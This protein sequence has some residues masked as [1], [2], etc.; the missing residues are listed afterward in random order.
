MT[1]A[2]AE[3]V[4]DIATLLDNHHLQKVVII[5]DAYNDLPTFDD[6]DED[7]AESIYQILIANGELLAQ[8][9]ATGMLMA[10][11]EDVTQ[12][13]WEF[14]WKLAPTDPALRAELE[15]LNIARNSTLKILG[16]LKKHLEG[17]LGRAVLEVAAERELPDASAQILFI[18]YFLDGTKRQSSLQIAKRLGQ[19][20]IELYS[21]SKSKPVIILMS[22]RQELTDEDKA[23]FRE[24]ANFVGGMFHYIPKKD[25]IDLGLLEVFLYLVTKTYPQG[26]AI[27][28]FVS[29]I[30]IAA[31]EALN[32]LKT[33]LQGLTVDDFGYIHQLTLAKEGVSLSDYVSSLLASFFNQEFRRRTL[34]DDQ[35]VDT[36]SFD[37]L[38]FHQEAP[39]LEFTKLFLGVV[40]Q[41]TADL[42]RHPQATQEAFPDGGNVPVDIHFGD[43]FVKGESV[44]LV[45]TAECDLIC[46][47]A[48]PK[49]R[50][51]DPEQKVLLVPGVL[52]K[53]DKPWKDLPSRTEFVAIE[54][55]S[56]SAV[57]WHFKRSTTHDLGSI[58][59]FIA[60]QGFSR[61]RRLNP[62][63][64]LDVQRMYFND[65]GRIGLPVG[66]PIYRNLGAKLCARGVDG[67]VH[68]LLEESL[69]TDQLCVSF[70]TRSEHVF[71]LTGEFLLRLP[72]AVKSA[73]DLLEEAREK[74]T[75]DKPKQKLAQKIAEL[76][77]IDLSQAKLDELRKPFMALK[78]NTEIACE[79]LK[80]I[81]VI[82]SKVMADEYVCEKP[83][84]LCLDSK[85][86][87]GEI[88]S[89]GV[90]PA[91]AV[92][93]ESNL[94][95][96]SAVAAEANV[97]DTLPAPHTT[98]SIADEVP[99]E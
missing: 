3:T 73:I 88:P 95:P 64:A 16:G 87:G 6:V 27:A 56:T 59:R 24:A 38:S 84:M 72:D 23:T 90:A 81:M 33:R 37:Q 8:V 47:P 19:R 60:D 79:P 89:P 36:L 14:L 57:Q 78:L 52:H 63:F 77:K 54:G 71:Q 98:E 82:S 20:I 22:N 7:V 13:V 51:F 21:G 58:A 25:L 97:P 18:D 11:A 40:S 65:M 93:T 4:R 91:A 12:E 94:I 44:L 10:N 85:S 67:K 46:T 70:L 61:K 49:F 96:V 35:V 53:Y 74:E 76:R 17:P 75:K 41:P 29:N 5:D 31:S 1:V 15:A 80:A 34:T 2:A 43:L 83:L 50:P 45:A 26:E 28:E 39:S 99:P 86:R 66:P 68:V 32:G 92:R 42:R 30:E 55:A 48:Q 9:A 69:S 62:E